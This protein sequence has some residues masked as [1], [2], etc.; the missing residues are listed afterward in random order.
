[1]LKKFNEKLILISGYLLF[2]LSLLIC[3]LIVWWAFSR[4]ILHKD[5]FGGEE[6]IVFFAFWMYFIGSAVASYQ[7]SHIVA[8]IVRSYLKT[9]QA[10]FL[11]EIIQLVITTFGFGVLTY[12]SYNLVQF[13]ILRNAVSTTFHYPLVAVHLALLISFILSFCYYIM[14]ICNAIIYYRN[15]K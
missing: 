11:Q 15:S 7:N 12:L 6:I 4:Y 14:H 5:F 8:D 1:M 13:D 9:P 2:I 3:I 10:L